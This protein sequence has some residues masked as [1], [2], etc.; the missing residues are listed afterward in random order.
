[1]YSEIWRTNQSAAV[2]VFWVGLQFAN[3]LTA[4][5]SMMCM[6]LGYITMSEK[7]T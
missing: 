1:M 7:T 3:F 2:A 6:M 5:I 4:S